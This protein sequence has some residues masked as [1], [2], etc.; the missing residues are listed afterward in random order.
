M[1][2]SMEEDIWDVYCLCCLC[3]RWMVSAIVSRDARAKT[4]TCKCLQ[5]GVSLIIYLEK[6]VFPQELSRG[7]MICRQKQKYTNIYEFCVFALHLPSGGQHSKSVNVRALP[8]GG[9]M[10]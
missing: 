7:R 1:D 5:K 8:R 6:R 9:G 10:P 2:M 4:P 3:H